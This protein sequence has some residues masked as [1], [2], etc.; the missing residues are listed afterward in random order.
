MLVKIDGVISQI[1]FNKEWTNKEGKLVP[2]SYSVILLGEENNDSISCS[3]P[4]ELANELNF[5]DSKIQK[6]YFLSPVTL[7]CDM[8][9]YNSKDKGDKV[10]FKIKSLQL[11]K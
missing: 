7:V 3:I 2:E 4:R 1:K 9:K 11:N 5:D 10:T 6:N 8:R